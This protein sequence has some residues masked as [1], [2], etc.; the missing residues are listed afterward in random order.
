MRDT[1]QSSKKV[2]HIISF[3]PI[4]ESPTS[5]SFHEPNVKLVRMDV[6]GTYWRAMNEEL[7]H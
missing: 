5:K 6:I 7:H 2:F 1:E 3:W 4:S